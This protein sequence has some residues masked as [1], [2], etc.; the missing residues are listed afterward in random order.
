MDVWCFPERKTIRMVRWMC[1]VSLKDR[2]PST[3]LRRRIWGHNEKVQTVF[4]VALIRIMQGRCRTL[5]L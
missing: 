5:C 2:E 4:E 3:E 1:G